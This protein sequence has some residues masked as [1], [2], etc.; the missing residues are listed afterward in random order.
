MQPILRLH[1]P[2]TCLVLYLGDLPDEVAGSD[3]CLLKIFTAAGKK[4]ITHKWLQADAPSVE[5]WLQ[6]VSKI[7]EMEKMTFC[8]RLNSARFK[9]K[10]KMDWS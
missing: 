6:I 2:K 8:L 1:I 7:F 4:A 5:R 3:R 10:G 9:K